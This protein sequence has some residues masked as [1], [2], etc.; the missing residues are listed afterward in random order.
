[1]KYLPKI[2]TLLTAQQQLQLPLLFLHSSLSAAKATLDTTFKNKQHETKVSPTF[3]STRQLQTLNSTQ[4]FL[5]DSELQEA[6]D[7]YCQNPNGWAN[8]TKYAIYG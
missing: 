2:V 4:S 8:S 1:M 7:E 6:V 3:S 5:S